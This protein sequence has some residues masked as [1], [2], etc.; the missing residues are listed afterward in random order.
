MQYMMCDVLF[1]IHDVSQYL[2]NLDLISLGTTKFILRGPFIYFL[3]FPQNKPLVYIKCMLYL[4]RPPK[5]II[6][7]ILGRD[8]SGE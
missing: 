8:R 4:T 1:V 5:V 2:E 3:I 6:M 7:M